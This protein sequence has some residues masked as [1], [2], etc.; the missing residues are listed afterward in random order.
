M[1]AAGSWRYLE[2][3]K[4]RDSLARRHMAIVFSPAGDTT[5]EERQNADGRPGTLA[6]E[7][8]VLRAVGD[9]K[10]GPNLLARKAKEATLVVRLS[11][12]TAGRPFTVALNEAW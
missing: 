1:A 11:V 7:F 2:V 6:H 9:G 8:R 5:S 3:V 12:R 4:L 10:D